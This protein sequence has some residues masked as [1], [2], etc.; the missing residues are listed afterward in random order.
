MLVILAWRNIWRNVRRSTIIIAA[1]TAGVMSGLF[2]SSLMF[3]LSESMVNSTIDRDLGHFQIHTPTFEDEKL[4]TD[5][6]PSAATVI[7]RAGHSRAVR[8]ISPRV[9][10]EGMGSSASTSNGVRIVGI[11]PAKEKTV[12]NIYRQLA[13]G[14]YFDSTRSAS[15]RRA[16][17]IVIG[18]KLADNLG[19]RERSKIILSFQGLDGTIIYGAFRV[20]GIFRTE[21]SMFDRTTVFVRESDLFALLNTAPVYHEIAVR[22]SADKFLDSASVPLRHELP[23][24]SVKTWKDLAPELKLL[25]ELVGLQLNIFL[26]II[27]FA[28]LFGI[29]NTMLMAVMERVREFGVLMAIGMK[30]RRVFVMIIMETLALSLVGGLLGM[31]F[32][33]VLIAYVGRVGIDLSA[34]SQG[35]T[36]WN[37]SPILQ[38]EL[39]FEF[40]LSITV[41]IIVTA[42]FSAIYPALKAVRLKPAHAI[43]SF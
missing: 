9:I 33:A 41:M 15:V 10:I 21:S 19:I 28:L 25:D 23:A 24:L 3:G 5:T 29:T 1:I 43:R 36:E 7:E 40:Y 13:V 14:S 18:Q 11:D 6:I 30:R 8:G 22:L 26:G 17:Q 42:I 39:P 35:F 16:N 31:A 34:F 32:A 20:T 37:M 2:A 27:L 4:L 38:P 12:T